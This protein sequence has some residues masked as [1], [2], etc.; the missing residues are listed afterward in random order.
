[1]SDKVLKITDHGTVR[2]IAIDRPDKLNALD[3]STLEALHHAFDQAA[4]DATVRVVVLTGSGPKAFVAG[5]DI[6]GSESRGVRVLGL[7]EGT[8]L[9]SAGP[10]FLR[11][12]RRRAAVGEAVSARRAL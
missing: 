9:N 4:T 3:A 1:M 7:D 6:G 10:R 12:V 2:V 8:A 11:V 5:A